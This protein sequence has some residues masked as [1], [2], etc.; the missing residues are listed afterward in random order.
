MKTRLLLLFASLF[1]LYTTYY[2][3]YGNS[4]FFVPKG[5]LNINP[6]DIG[7]LVI[8]IKEKS[9]GFV[10][11]NHEWKLV[12]PYAKGVDQR[13]FTFFLRNLTM[14]S[15]TSSSIHLVSWARQ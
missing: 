13:S 10:K 9:Y 5:F 12:T 7:S 15:I 6:S 2:V 8:F 11:E 1:I 14:M 3:S 4:K